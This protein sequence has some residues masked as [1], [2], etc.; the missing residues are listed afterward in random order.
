MFIVA[1]TIKLPAHPWELQLRTPKTAPVEKGDV[2]LATFWVRSK[3]DSAETVCVFERA[4]VPY[5]KS[6]SFPVE[7]TAEWKKL[8]LPFVSLDRYPAGRAAVNFQIG[9]GKQTIDIGGVQVVNCGPNAKLSDLPRTRASYAGRE[10]DAPWRRSAAERIEK[11][12]KA[13]LSVT[14]KD[15]SGKPL[16][17][18]TVDVRMTR[19]AFGFGS[20]VSSE[21][22]LGKGSDDEKYRQQVKALFN[23]VVLENDLKWPQ[24]ESDRRRG[25]DAVDWLA[26]L[27]R[28]RLRAW[29][30]SSRTLRALNASQARPL[31]KCP[32]A[33]QDSQFQ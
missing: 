25:L 21:H 15:A 10:P 7:A 5:E 32:V 9:F 1:E 16:A 31:N 13:D 18:A 30:T 2:L 24:W 6:L 27:Q 23:R 17:G 29:T 33:A 20:A 3:G 26:A 14:V 19:H 28:P 22:L 11:I 4:A 12:R 8:E